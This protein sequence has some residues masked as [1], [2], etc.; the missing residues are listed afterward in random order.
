MTVKAENLLL[1]PAPLHGLAD[2]HPLV[3]RQRIHG[4]TVALIRA[5]DL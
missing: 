4:C 1:L 3:T 5:R 2:A